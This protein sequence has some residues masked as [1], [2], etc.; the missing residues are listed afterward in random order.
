MAAGK[1]SVARW[2][3]IL[4]RSCALGLINVVEG[5]HTP[6]GFSSPDPWA[7]LNGLSH[8]CRSGLVHAAAV[9]RKGIEGPSPRDCH[10]YL[11]TIE[12]R[13]ELIIDE[14]A[15]FLVVETVHSR[16]DFLTPMD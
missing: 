10:F 6:L 3:S 13:R 2:G 5:R 14:L 1:G 7:V 16:S 8:F 11:L 12:L 4:S 15:W 9:G